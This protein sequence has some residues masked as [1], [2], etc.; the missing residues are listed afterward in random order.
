ML[1]NEFLSVTN[2]SSS[3]PSLIILYICYFYALVIKLNSFSL[4]GSTK[5]I[6]SG[7]QHTK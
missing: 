7:R 5:C 3:F 6:L 2:K 1:V 4:N